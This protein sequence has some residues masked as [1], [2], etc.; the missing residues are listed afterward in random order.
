MV[1]DDEV[2]NLNKIIHRKNNIALVYFYDMTG[3]IIS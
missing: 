2:K 1:N 3:E